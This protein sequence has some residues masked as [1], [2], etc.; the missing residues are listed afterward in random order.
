MH[1]GLLAWI[2]VDSKVQSLATCKELSSI[3]V[4]YESIST[5]NASLSLSMMNNNQLCI[6]FCTLTSSIGHTVLRSFQRPSMTA[7]RD[8]AFS[9]MSAELFGNLGKQYLTWLDPPE[10]IFI[11]SSP[12]LA[13]STSTGPATLSSPAAPATQ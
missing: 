8:P 7:R 5:P 6:L 1:T 13:S 3:H 12:P 4:S 2:E 9:I 10:A 11:R